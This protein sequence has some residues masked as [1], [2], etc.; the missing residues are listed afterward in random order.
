[1]LV[2]NFK[3]TSLTAPVMTQFFLAT[4][5][6]ALTGRSHT[7]KVFTKVWIGDIYKSYIL[8]AYKFRFE[9]FIFMVQVVNI[10]FTC[11]SWFQ[12]QTLPLYRLASIHG[13]VGWRSTLFT[14]SDRAVSFRLMSSLR[15][16]ETDVKSIQINRQGS[17]Q[18]T[19]LIAE[20]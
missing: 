13:S 19:H 14:R 8:I 1:M 6:D 5:F 10:M 7:S 3:S 4:N 11:V 17:A 12:T 16:F 20:S 2:L 15:G 18:R 9:L